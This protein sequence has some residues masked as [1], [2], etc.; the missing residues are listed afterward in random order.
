MQ[1]V[2]FLYYLLLAMYS[3]TVNILVLLRPA[4]QQNKKRRLTNDADRIGALS[5]LY[6]FRDSL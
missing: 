5:D 2:E 4:K 3:Y 1:I 6:P